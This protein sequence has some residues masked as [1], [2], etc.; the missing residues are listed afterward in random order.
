MEQIPNVDAVFVP[1]GGGGLIAGIAMAI[2]NINPNVDVIGVEPVSYPVSY[3]TNYILHSFYKNLILYYI[4][5]FNCSIT[6][7]SICRIRKSKK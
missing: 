1:V 7:K 2:K 6:C 3:L 5:E 4:L